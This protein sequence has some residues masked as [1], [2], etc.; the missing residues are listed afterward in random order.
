MASKAVKRCRA[1]FKKLAVL[2]DLQQD[3]L[4]AQGARLEKKR[5]QDSWG[6]R[7]DKNLRGFFNHKTARDVKRGVYA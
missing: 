2:N 6:N 3:E 1:K 4:M 5:M 7:Q